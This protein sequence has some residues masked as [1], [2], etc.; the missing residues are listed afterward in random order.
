MIFVKYN[1]LENHYR[2]NVIDSFATSGYT[3]KGVEWVA[4]EKIHGTNFQLAVNDEHVQAGR[5]TD[6]LGDFDQFY[7]ADLIVKKYHDNARKVYNFVKQKHPEVDQVTIFGEYAG[8]LTTGK[9][10]QKEVEYGDQD[11]YVF[12]IFIFSGETGMYLSHDFVMD[13]IDGIF[14]HA[15]VIY[16]GDFDGVTK[17][18]NDFQSVVIPSN[19]AGK[20]D[21]VEGTDNI[22]EGFVAKTVDPHYTRQGRTIFKSKNSKFTEKGKSDK[23]VK[24]KEPLGESDLAMIHEIAE[25]INVNRLKNVLSKIGIPTTKEFGKVSGNLSKDAIEDFTKDTSKNL[26]DAERPSD[27]GK[28]VNNLAGELVREHWMNILDGNF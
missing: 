22:A 10:I 28:A 2:Q 3:A 14:K 8:N 27:V 26:R 1:S 4:M 13:A 16:R 21:L 18:P 9:M 23:P 5:R 15:P 24:V 25:Y 7:E 11:F 19:I 20:F 12:D 17:L 6:L